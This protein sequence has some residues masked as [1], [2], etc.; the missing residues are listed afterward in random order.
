MPTSAA[1]RTPHRYTPST[2]FDQE[3]LCR[4]LFQHLLACACTS[5]YSTYSHCSAHALW[6]IVVLLPLTEVPA[7]DAALRP[8]SVSTHQNVAVHAPT[9]LKV[10]PH[11]MTEVLIPHHATA[12]MYPLCGNPILDE[13]ILQ[14][15][16]VD[17]QRQGQ[18]TA[19]GGCGSI[20]LD[21]PAFPVSYT[22]L[23]A[24][25]SVPCLH[26]TFRYSR[27]DCGTH[28]SQRSQRV[29]LNLNGSAKRA[30]SAW[31]VPRHVHQRLSGSSAMPRPVRRG[32]H[33]QQ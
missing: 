32:H 10:N 30:C 27:N 17:G 11:P 3:I 7:F 19:P 1:S 18:P 9:S 24:R 20:K 15:N 29:G 8:D 12:G 22:I 4:P 21:Q 2:V 16:A 14:H 26:A 28:F 25:K 6:Q 23:D 33:R 13:D 5:P 31:L